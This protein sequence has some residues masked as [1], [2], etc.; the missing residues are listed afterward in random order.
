MLDGMKFEAVDSIEDKGFTLLPSPPQVKTPIHSLPF[1]GLSGIETSARVQASALFFFGSVARTVGPRISGTY[2]HPSP[3][4]HLLCSSTLCLPRSLRCWLACRN[5]NIC[6]HHTR[7]RASWGPFIATTRCN[8]S[9]QV[10]GDRHQL[11]GCVRAPSLA[12]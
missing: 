9:P 8:I 2:L 4:P 1:L 6:V 11:A 7:H 5:D 10:L 12:W 3:R